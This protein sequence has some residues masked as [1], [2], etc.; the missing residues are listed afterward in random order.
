M[1]L[2]TLTSP[3][4]QPQEHQP[5]SS[6]VQLAADTLRSLLLFYRLI[7]VETSS[8]QLRAPVML[9]VLDVDH[10]LTLGPWLYF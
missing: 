8:N 5:A 3:P 7:L 2:Q 1:L 10:N 6:T 9:P 4:S